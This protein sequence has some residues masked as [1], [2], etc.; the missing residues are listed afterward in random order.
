MTAPNNDKRFVLALIGPR[1]IAPQTWTNNG[2]DD[3]LEVENATPADRIYEARTVN[4]SFN[5]RIAACP[6]KYQDHTSA[7]V[8]ICN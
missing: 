1:A 4:S 7:D 6:F 3:Y 8:V 5:D 2:P